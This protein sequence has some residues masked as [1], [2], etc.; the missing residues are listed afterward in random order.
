MIGPA[1]VCWSRKTRGIFWTVYKLQ[2]CFLSRSTNYSITITLLI[3]L[4][5]QVIICR[6]K[7]QFRVVI[8]SSASRRYCWP[9]VSVS[10]GVCSAFRPPP[11][12]DIMLSDLTQATLGAQLP[13]A[14]APRPAQ[15]TATSRSRNRPANKLCDLVSYLQWA[16]GVRGELKNV[17]YTTDGVLLS[18]FT[19]P[20]QTWT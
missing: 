20:L 10:A 17:T 1:V 4:A 6:M 9:R 8:W 13:V 12:C 16:V 14:T 5:I 18:M 7:I 2:T 11:R 3:L 15:P 19:R